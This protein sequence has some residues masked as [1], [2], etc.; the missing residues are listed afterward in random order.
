MDQ[1]IYQK[2]V[3]SEPLGF[4]NPFEDLG[5]F[6]SVLMKFVEP[7]EMLVNKYSDTPYSPYW[8]EKIKEMRKLYVE[9]METCQE[10]DSL[11]YRLRNKETKAHADEIVT[12]YLRLGFRFKEIEKRI[13][14]PIKRLRRYWR[15]S[16]YIKTAKPYFYLKSNLIVGNSEPERILPV[17]LTLKNNKE[18]YDDKKH[19]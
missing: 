15:R 14:F 8:Q 11:N 18:V 17:S 19:L 5:T 13:V 7:V 2:L 16:D 10:N 9:Y 1:F 12:T 3:E 6:D 4:I